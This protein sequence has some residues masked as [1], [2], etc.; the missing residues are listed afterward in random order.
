MEKDDLFKQIRG[1]G[2]FKRKKNTQENVNVIDYYQKD[3]LKL[4][5]NLN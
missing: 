5:E 3:I 1:F 2:G 4:A